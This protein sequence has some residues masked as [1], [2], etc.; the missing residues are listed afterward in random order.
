MESVLNFVTEGWSTTDEGDPAEDGCPDRS[1]S[2][3]SSSP[4]G[5]T[6]NSIFQLDLVV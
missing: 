3:E 5:K 4:S 6:F 1:K 2:S